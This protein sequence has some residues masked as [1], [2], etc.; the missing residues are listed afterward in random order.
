MRLRA[1][2]GQFDAVLAANLLCRL[3]DPRLCV[4]N[5]PALVRPGGQLVIAT[6]CTW[7]EAFTPAAH[8]LGGFE[9]N[10]ARVTTLQSLSEMLEPAF[11][12]KRGFDLPFLIREHAR[13]FQWNVA[14]VSVWK[15]R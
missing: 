12:L 11:E 9:R 7:L 1:G 6:P 15:R 3:R 5:F 8:W 4:E 13:K 2:L 14:Q 10:G